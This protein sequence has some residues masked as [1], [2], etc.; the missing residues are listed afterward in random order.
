M[1]RRSPPVPSST[2]PLRQEAQIAIVGGGI[3]GLATAYNLAALGLRDVVVLEG[4]HL[5]S[6]ASGRNGGGVRQQWSTELNIRLMQESLELCR[7]FAQE[8][9]VNI[10]MREGG[11]LFLAKE[12]V[13]LE[14]M[15]KAI[16]LQNRCGVPT[17]LL[18]AGEALRIVPELADGPFVGACYNPTDAIVFP[19]PFLWG[20]GRAAAERGVEIHTATPVTAIEAGARGFLLRTHKGTL[21]AERVL[22]AAGAWSPQVARLVGLD[23]PTWPARHEILSTEALK[24]FLRPMVA[25]LD[26]GLY[27]SQSLRGEVVGGITLPEPR[28]REIQLGSRLHFLERMAA[29]LCEAMPR[30]GH[31][32]VVRQWA[33][34]YDMSPDNDPIVGEAPALPGFFVCSGF[35]GHGFMM[36]PVV[37]KHYARHLL[38]HGNHPLFDAWAWRSERFAGTGRA[39]EDFNLG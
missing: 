24:P 4:G 1:R 14:R 29:A 22:A 9:G 3:M 37:G 10:W 19:W 11:Y 15:E 5:A 38:G 28:T 16:A 35:V 26:S 25:V 18:E 34:P 17:R 8:M 32:K 13:Q 30:L 39:G 36:A 27:F 12:R 6:G 7:G 33:G 31:L 2:A 20:Y 23:L 21:R